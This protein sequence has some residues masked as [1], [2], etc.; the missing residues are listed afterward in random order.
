MWALAIA[1]AALT[2]YG[3]AANGILAQPIWSEAGL[4]RFAWFTA[5]YWI[6]ALVARRYLAA[7][8]CAVAVVYACAAVGVQAVGAAAIVVAASFGVGSRLGASGAVQAI[9]LGLGC[10][11][12]LTGWLVRF[13]V[14][15]TALYAVLVGAG[16]TLGA[17]KLRDALRG[18]RL[19]AAPF[20]VTLPLYVACVHLLAALFPEASSDG[21]AMHLTVPAWVAAH[22]SWHFD[23][24]RFSWAL[25]PMAGDWAHTVAYLLGGEAAAR[26]LNFAMLVVLAALVYSLV[27]RVAGT[28]AALLAAALW[29]STPVAYLATG[30]LFVENFWTL[31]ACAAVAAVADYR[32]N[33]NPRSLMVAGA[34]GGFAL[35]GKLL[36]LPVVGVAA[37]AALIEVL[38]R[39]RRGALAGLALLAVLGLPPYVGAWVKT[40]NPVFPTFNSLFASP[41]FAGNLPFG[42]P[43]YPA[44]LRWDLLYDATF[45]SAKYLE[46]HKGSL[47]LHYLLLLPLSLLLLRRRAPWLI[48]FAL[49]TSLIAIVSV[50]SAMGYLRYIYPALALLCVV[51]GW[52]LD[53]M[54]R[55]D[56]RMRMVSLAAVATVIVGNTYLFSTATPYTRDFALPMSGA[57]EYLRQAAPIRQ[58][59]TRLN[60]VAPGEPVAFFDDDQVAGLRGRAYTASWR[61]WTFERVLDAAKSPG[62]VLR[63]LRNRGIRHAIS[64]SARAPVAA[65]HPAAQGLL[66]ACGRVEAESG[67]FAT[68]RI[69]TS[70]E[71]ADRL[72]FDEAPVA[73]P[74]ANDDF[75]PFVHYYG[76]WVHDRQF[77]EAGSH[78]LTYTYIA[79]DWVQ[80]RFQGRRVRVVYTAA[81]NRGTA[82]VVLDGRVVASLDQHSPQTQWQAEAVYDAGSEG[83]HT[84]RLE[85]TGGGY[86]DVDGFVVE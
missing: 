62:D 29:L 64:L 72:Y 38:R 76:Q 54:A 33:G 65:R 48:L 77:A 78:T 85:L 22:G 3:V 16:V 19:G 15:T 37:V 18:I 40:G 28:T 26:L 57:A 47:G 69:D 8:V 21:L 24:D 75:R 31:M 51:F 30:S 25:M 6:L 4:R 34:L 9:A 43:R 36:A 32:E 2:V 46:G 17:G 68:W 20:A 42:M 86:L 73:T 74:G 58:L 11:A 12:V 70:C 27:R 53:E 14:D 81:A 71:H 44:A 80:L 45:N 55:V 13:P 84:L 39:P 5:G 49:V 52:T 79:G 1:L 10:Y 67:A 63:E 23:V 50:F 61:T 7:V 82:S 83:M 59:V 66:R 41:L 60:D 56:R 35:S